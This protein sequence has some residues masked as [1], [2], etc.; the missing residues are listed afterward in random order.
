V[1]EE[2]I[3]LASSEDEEEAAATGMLSAANTELDAVAAAVVLEGATD[4]EAATSSSPIVGAAAYSRIDS[5]FCWLRDC[6]RDECG[7][8]GGSDGLTVVAAA[9]AAPPPASAWMAG[10]GTVAES[11]T[12]AESGAPLMAARG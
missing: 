8:D 4:E 1:S 6:E 12:E 7:R 11:R 3:A 5:R 2:S 9:L 10:E